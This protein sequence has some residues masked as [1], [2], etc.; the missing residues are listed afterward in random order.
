MHQ[1]VGHFV[2]AFR[3]IYNYIDMYCVHSV[4]TIDIYIIIIIIHI[5]KDMSII[6]VSI[7]ISCM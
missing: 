6:V 3:Y 4:H 5:S 1:L 7:Y 2:D